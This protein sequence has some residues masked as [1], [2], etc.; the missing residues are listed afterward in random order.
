M[1]QKRFRDKCTIKGDI[2]NFGEDGPLKK[3]LDVRA[4]QELK[5]L[6]SGLTASDVRQLGCEKAPYIM[7]RTFVKAYQTYNKNEKKDSKEE[8]L[9]DTWLIQR[10]YLKFNYPS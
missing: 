7:S 9:D 1:K 8:D 3:V 6:P 5:Q 2:V 4:S 10:H